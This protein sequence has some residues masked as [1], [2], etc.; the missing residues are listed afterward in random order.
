MDIETDVDRVRLLAEAK[1]D[2]N[3]RF[4]AYLNCL[5]PLPSPYLFV[6]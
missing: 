2:G 5:S 6:G 1:E 3:W 4:R